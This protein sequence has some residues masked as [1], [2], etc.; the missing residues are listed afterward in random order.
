[1]YPWYKDNK[2]GLINEIQSMFMHKVGPGIL[3]PKQNE[4]SNKGNLLGLISPHAAF[5][6]SGPTTSHGI[7][8]LAKDRQNIDTIIVLGNKHTPYG[9][10]VSLGAY[11]LWETP[12][13]SVPINN[14]LLDRIN[15]SKRNLPKNLKTHIDYDT[16]AHNQEH[17]I[18]IQVPFL[19]FIFKDFK[20]APIA[21]GHLSSE[22]TNVL[23]K[24][25]AQIIKKADL[26]DSI[27][28]IAS[29][30]MTHG[31]Y[32]PIL[33]HEQV[34][35]LDKKALDKILKRNPQELEKVV[36]KYHIS[37]CGVSPV[38]V[39]MSLTDELGAQSAKLLNYSTSG[40]TCGDKSSV[41][42]YASVGFFK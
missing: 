2:E 10:S 42:G 27:V 25:F 41:V 30:D 28:V 35:E 23:G 3:P 20:I 37:M 15:A 8:E 38:N 14:K 4:R 21:I 13:A 22:T 34:T 24:Y 5:A 29:S 12:I 1:M 6:C 7:L 33:N 19:Q 36:Q 18:E 9:P 16:S 17:S 11:D 26:Q 31:N 40:L 32:S 39:L